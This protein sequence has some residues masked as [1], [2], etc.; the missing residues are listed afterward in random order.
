MS[1]D[2]DLDVCRYIYK[3]LVTFRPNVHCP[4]LGTEDGFGCGTR[5]YTDLTTVYPFTTS[6]LSVNIT[7][8]GTEGLP[9]DTLEE[10]MRMNMLEI[11]P[12]TVAFY[13]IPIFLYILLLYV[14]S[15]FTEVALFRFS[16][17]FVGLSFE[18][19]RNTI[20]YAMNAFY[21]TVAL[22]LQ[23]FASPMLLERYTVD[24]MGAV[25]VVSLVISGLYLFEMIYRPNMRWPLLIHHFC[26]LFSV[27]FLQV[28]LQITSTRPFW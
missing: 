20:T 25:R 4:R 13:G 23:L 18:N 22:A 8:S 19:R 6:L 3:D 24:R 14:S 16:S 27:I 11:Y 28:A 9:A 12:T 15:K 1:V 26:T 21:T 2:S 10:L 7:G 5:S 17:V